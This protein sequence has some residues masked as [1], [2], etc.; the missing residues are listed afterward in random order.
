MEIIP[1]KKNPIA[2]DLMKSHFAWIAFRRQDFRKEIYSTTVFP[3]HLYQI[4]HSYMLPVDDIYA[5]F[6][7]RETKKEEKTS[8]YIYAR[9]WNLLKYYDSGLTCP[10]YS[11]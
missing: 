3:L 1:Y 9:T 8:V 5:E 4:M 2:E 11:N 7:R 6:N 10:M